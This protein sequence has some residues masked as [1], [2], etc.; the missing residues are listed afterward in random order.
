MSLQSDHPLAAHGFT[1][2]TQT[3]IKYDRVC[4]FALAAPP[5]SPFS[6]PSV[7]SLPNS[8]VAHYTHPRLVAGK[9]QCE[10]YLSPSPSHSYRSYRTFASPFSS[11]VQ[12]DERRL[13]YLPELMGGFSD[14]LFARQYEK[15]I[16]TSPQ[17]PF[18]LRPPSIG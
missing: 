18:H 3:K 1:D 11:F 7:P 8:R 13:A 16:L 5:S 10:G 14:M 9:L 15:A 4:E 12:N 17:S 6:V 2:P